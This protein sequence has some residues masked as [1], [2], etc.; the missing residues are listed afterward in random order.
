VKKRP[1]AV[2]LG[3]IGAEP[4]RR[5]RKASSEIIESLRRGIAGGEL[6]RG[7]RLPPEGDLA[8]HF[9]VSQPTVREALRVLEA[10]GLIEVRHGSG[11]YVTG[12][13]HQFMATS[14]HTVM[15]MDQVGIVDLVEMRSA[16]A[17]YSAARVVRCASDDDLEVI[18]EQESRLEEAAQLSDF[19]HIGDAAVAF[20][21]SVSAAAHNPLLLAIESVL[22]EL[23]VR[24][25]MDAFSRRSASFWRNWSLHFANDRQ[26]LIE[27]FRAR[28]EARAV[29]AMRQYLDRQRTRFSSDETL[30][31]A[32]VSDPEV[33][34][35]IESIISS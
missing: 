29:H 5:R 15:Q 11:A 12:D 26:E 2:D 30:S 33:M 20:Q 9:S 10:M 32:R 18:E 8:A 16:L 19:R 31:R 7:E 13:P 21:V 14:L 3:S 4:G 1:E 24:L 22:A 25:Q 27:S 35:V 6:Q 28:D 34:R 23:L 17:D